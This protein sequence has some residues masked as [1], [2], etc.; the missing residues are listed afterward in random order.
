MQNEY[1]KPICPLMSCRDGACPCIES[2]CAWWDTLHERC[3]VST[4][5]DTPVSYTHLDVYKRQTVRQKSG[6]VLSVTGV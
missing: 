5:A 3:S 2:G 1:D 4:I 6:I